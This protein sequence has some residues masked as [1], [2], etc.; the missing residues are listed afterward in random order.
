[1]VYSWK[2]PMD[3]QRSSSRQSGPSLLPADNEFKEQVIRLMDEEVI[4]RF[5][6][7][8]GNAEDFYEDPD[9]LSVLIQYRRSRL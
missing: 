7:R 9:E 3:I 5:D 8:A 2:L 6:Q 1:M 4:Q